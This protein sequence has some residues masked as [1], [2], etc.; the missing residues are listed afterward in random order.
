MAGLKKRALGTGKLPIKLLE[1]LLK[2][3]ARPGRGVIV[4]AGIG[5]DA[6]V[7]D[8]KGGYLIAKTDPITFVADDIGLYAIHINA[9]DI[10]VMGGTPGWF[11][12]T[13][14]LPEGTSGFRAVEKVFSEMHKACSSIGV[15]L[16]GGHTEITRAVRKTVVVGQML[17]TVS[18][19]RLVTAEGARAGDDLILTKGIAIEAT[20]IM[21]REKGKELLRKG[22]SPGFIRR[23]RDFIR[24]PGISVLKDAAAALRSGRVHAMHDPTEGGLSTGLHELAIASGKG[25]VVEKELIP[26]YPETGRLCAI[27]RI[28]PMG[29]IASGS[30][31]AAVDPR[32]TGKVIKGLKEAGVPACRIGRVTA[33]EEGVRISERGKT[34]PL[35]MPERDELARIF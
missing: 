22:L 21:A 19:E 26:V 13:V 10:A 4:G 31:L 24:R 5:I 18:K 15:S 7:I 17:G 11:L 33:K 28:D 14:L 20:S 6:T 1:R 32:D 27:F 25:V 16:C 35:K 8:F 23:C 34:R 3:Y 29:S 30:L 2:R 12:A 9:N